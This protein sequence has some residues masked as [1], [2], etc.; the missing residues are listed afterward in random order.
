MA[1]G[2]RDAGL[3]GRGIAAIALSVG[4][5][6]CTAPSSMLVRSGDEPRYEDDD[7]AFR[8]IYY[9]RVFDACEG[10]R[11]G[12]AGVSRATADG[13]VDYTKLFDAQKGP[14]RL[15]TDSLYR[16]RMTGKA[17]TL[18][19]R[20]HFESGTLRKEQIDPFGANVA[21][22]KANSRFYFKSQEDTQADARQTEA[23]DRIK[24]LRQT[25]DELAGKDSKDP[26]R[27]DQLAAVDQLIVENLAR[28]SSRGAV[29]SSGLG[30]VH[31]VTPETVAR[32]SAIVSSVQQIEA[33]FD[34]GNLSIAI[35]AANAASG[36]GAYA[37]V[38]TAADKF[39]TRTSTGSRDAMVEIA[40]AIASD[41]VGAAFAKA[42]AEVSAA[43]AKVASSDLRSAANLLSLRSA[44]RDARIKALAALVTT[45][46]AIATAPTLEMLDE[47]K[48]KA[49]EIEAI[50]R[51]DADSVQAA[52]ASAIRALDGRKDPEAAE[53]RKAID[54]IEILAKAVSPWRMAAVRMTGAVGT[55]R[56]A[57]AVKAAADAAKTQVAKLPGAMAAVYAKANPS[58]PLAVG[59]KAV[60]QLET[61]AKT[62]NLYASLARAG[63]SVPPPTHKPPSGYASFFAASQAWTAV[64]AG[65]GRE[66]T[67]TLLA[68]AKAVDGLVAS[69]TA[70]ADATGK[71]ASLLPAD[72]E[73]E[74]KAAVS[75]AQATLVR[76]A[77]DAGDAAKALRG[78]ALA[79]ADLPLA[80]PVQAVKPGT[81]PLCED[82]I[83]ARRGF[84]VLGPEGWRTFDQNERLIM[85]MSTSARPLISTLNEIS[86]RILNTATNPSDTLLP[87]MQ[88]RLRAT[89]AKHRG[90][91]TASAISATVALQNI[92]D[93]FRSP[94][95]PTDEG[96]TR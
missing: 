12:F 21:F 73:P 20:I 55:Y 57:T 64:V 62:G 18:G 16:F 31:E 90:D 91:R 71:I 37:N 72:A 81:S 40:T 53:I 52:S 6:G 35:G 95:D 43:A 48:R 58:L 7:V 92:I 15:L 79:A 69:A 34:T 45:A 8:T 49:A 50:A 74:T 68:A 41:T 23:L 54:A 26:A 93:S 80:T 60:D 65:K 33:A 83:V 67:S 94:T 38:V 89:E 14:P 36:A 77:G 19:S 2:R 70:A 82:G 1:G 10:E 22:D 3:L 42:S 39:V 5:A 29:S 59:K 84:Q 44:D 78:Q 4:V 25:R 46:G 88:E 47:A 9:F 32:A 13:K 63:D 66:A 87:L 51:S 28:L 24:A 86:G 56:T 76:I 85:A 27:R 61:E 30:S 75:D 96:A 11:P 17:S